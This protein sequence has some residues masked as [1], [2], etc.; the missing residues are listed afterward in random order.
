[1]NDILLDPL[2]EH[3]KIH[4]C[5]L[6]NSEI[7]KNEWKIQNWHEMPIDVFVH[8]HCGNKSKKAVNL[9]VQ[10]SGRPNVNEKFPNA[11]STGL[12][13]LLIFAALLT[14]YFVGQQKSTLS[15]DPI[16]MQPF[17]R[18]YC[19]GVVFFLLLKFCHKKWNEKPKKWT[20]SIM[21]FIEAQM[22]CQTER[23][24]CENQNRFYFS[25]SVYFFVRRVW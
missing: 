5:T 6:W 3:V 23:C 16:R 14:L 24:P 10:L 13:P 1:M 15:I 21:K 8:L 20:F 11:L 4:T 12:R 9:N 19:V 17:I 22:E 25:A 2:I 18:I 7:A